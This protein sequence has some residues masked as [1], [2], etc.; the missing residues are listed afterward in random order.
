MTPQE[1]NLLFNPLYRSFVNLVEL[2]DE[3]R[4]LHLAHY[5]SLEV[6]EKIIQN[7]EIWFSNPL[8]MNDHQEMRF[9]IFEAVKLLNQLVQDNDVVASVGGSENFALVSNAFHASLQNFDVNHSL[10]VYVCCLSQYDAVSQPDGRLSMWRGYGANGHGAA[11]VFNTQ[12]ATLVPE[13]PLLIAKVEYA[14]AFERIERLRAIF[15]GC[16]SLLRRTTINHESLWLVGFHMFHLALMY[17]LLSKHPGFKEEEE[18]RLIY[19]PHLD[20]RGLLKDN[21]TYLRRNNTIEPKLRFPIKPLEIE[22]QQLWTFDS[23]LYR[24]VLGPTH[25]SILAVNS[26]KRMLQSLGKPDFAT[27]IWVSEIPYRPTGG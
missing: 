13:S 27:K 24:I 22:P 12:F 5:T 25:G 26:A 14:S 23:I 15:L 19:M 6:L 2:T 21:R 20:G 18:W 11:L 7:N 16:I 3:Q 9:G 8:F 10:D 4:P 17:S 1:F